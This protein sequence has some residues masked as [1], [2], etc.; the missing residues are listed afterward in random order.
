[1]LQRPAYDIAPG[2]W[3]I[4]IVAEDAINAFAFVGD[5]GQ[6]TLMDAGLPW[7]GKRIDAG[8]KYLGSD[9]SEVTRILV[10]HA[11]N[12]HVGGVARVAK[13]S[14][15]PVMSHTDDANWIRLGQTPPID[16]RIKFRPLLRRWGKFP[17]V[18]VAETFTDGDLLDLAGGIRAIHTPGHTP[19]HT[20]FLHEPTGVLVT[21]D[22]VHFW[23]GRIRIGI[24]LFCNDIALNEKSVQRFSEM[25]Y[26][27]LAFTHG[28]EIRTAGKAAMRKFM[29]SGR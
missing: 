16:S 6:V 18:E 10:T 28:P 29:A 14:G 20:S 27:G 26:D 4:P 15:A 23:R 11:H 12:D 1:M 3:R 2:I 5:D 13:A 22:A 21:G 24:K 7:A 17:A 19:G 8:L 9:T 25:D